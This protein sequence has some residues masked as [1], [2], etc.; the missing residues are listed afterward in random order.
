MVIIVVIAECFTK[1]YLEFNQFCTK[2][3]WLMQHLYMGHYDTRWILHKLNLSIHIVNCTVSVCTRESSWNP[4]SCTATWL[5]PAQ[6]ASQLP[7]APSPSNKLLPSLSHY[8]FIPS[9][10]SMAWF[11]KIIFCFLKIWLK[12]AQLSNCITWNFLSLGVSLVWMWAV[13]QT[14][15]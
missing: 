6:P 13:P 9:V 2:T 12:T 7:P 5:V 3:P 15:L 8:S 11:P 10:K 14:E 1:Y 4:Q